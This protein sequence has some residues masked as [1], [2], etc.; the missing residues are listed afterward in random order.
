M[1]AIR[2]HQAELDA[3]IAR[4][5]AAAEVIREL[6]RLDSDPGADQLASGHGHGSPTDT[7]DGEAPISLADLSA[8]EAALYVLQQ[9]AVTRRGMHY[10]QIH[11][12][13][14][15]LGWTG[16]EQNIRRTVN[17]CHDEFV[18]LGNGWYRLSATVAAPQED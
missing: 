17:H 5:E 2:A 8:R 12:R 1:D 18:A 7:D 10:K 3:E 14:A 6:D 4:L 16:N 9:F 11:R 13:A 15:E